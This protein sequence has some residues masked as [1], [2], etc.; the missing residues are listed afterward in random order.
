MRRADLEQEHAANVFPRPLK[1]RERAGHA[2]RTALGAMSSFSVENGE[3]GMRPY[4]ALGV[5]MS[6]SASP[7]RL[8]EKIKAVTT[9][10]GKASK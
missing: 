8:K 9:P 2:L 4:L 7:S 3:G 10:A 1:V 5:K 6:V